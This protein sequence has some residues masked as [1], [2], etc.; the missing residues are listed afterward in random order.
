ML[1]RSLVRIA[2]EH[3]VSR[4]TGPQI[5]DDHAMHERVFME[6][7]KALAQG[8]HGV[9]AIFQQGRL[10]ASGAQPEQVL[11]SALQAG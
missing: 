3:N 10:I 4:V 6:E 7:E 2:Q 5:F 8:I 1:F 9:P 11:A